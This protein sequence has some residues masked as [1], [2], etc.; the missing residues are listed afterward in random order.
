MSNERITISGRSS[1]QNAS[2]AF[3]GTVTGEDGKKSKGIIPKDTR[4]F[5]AVQAQNHC[6]V[7]PLFCSLP[8]ANSETL[9]LLKATAITARVGQGHSI[10]N[11]FMLWL[12][13][14][15]WYCMWRNMCRSNE[16]S[17]PFIGQLPIQM[18]DG[19]ASAVT[20]F[21]AKSRTDFNVRIATNN[22]YILHVELLKKRAATNLDRHF[23]YS[24]NLIGLKKRK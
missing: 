6:A 5:T 4:S 11:M 12:F 16:S 13:H 2:S 20:T 14:A 21:G 15:V 22:G 7:Q 9:I 19:E 17:S 23:R 18:A 8:Y 3:C 24:K 10:A 1:S